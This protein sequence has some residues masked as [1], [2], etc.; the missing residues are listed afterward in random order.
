MTREPDCATCGEAPAH[1]LGE[2]CLACSAAWLIHGPYATQCLESMRKI[3][4]GTTAMNA[5]ELEI[6]RQLSAI[7]A[8][9]R[10]VA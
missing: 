10:Q 2:D 8:A 5:L 4:G 6:E 3:H 7:V 9:G 1:A